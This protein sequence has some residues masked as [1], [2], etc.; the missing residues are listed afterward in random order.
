MPRLPGESGVAP[1]R[2]GRRW[3][4]RWGWENLGAPGVHH[5]AAVRLLVVADAHHVDR[6]F[7]AEELA[8]QR[9]RAAPLSGPGLGGQPLDAGALV[10]V[11]LRHRGVGLVAAGR[12]GAFVL[13]IDVRRRVERLFQAARA[14]ERRGPP[15]AVDIHH[16]AR[17]I[18]LRLGAR[19]PARSAPSER[20]EPGPAASAAR[21]FADS[22]AGPC[23]S[24]SDGS[25]LTQTEGIWVGKKELRNFRHGRLI[26]IRLPAGA[27]P[28]S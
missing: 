3:C 16:L 10:V 20:W 21:G 23:G 1:A 19:T 24:G 27:P 22:A 26:V 17:D 8:G 25:T 11:R 9:Q 4:G 15:Q 2:R 18:D 6:A 13:V 7:H 14:I 12:A 28:Q 5:H